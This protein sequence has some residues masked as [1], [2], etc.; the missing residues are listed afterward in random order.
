MWLSVKSMWQVKKISESIFG[1]DISRILIVLDLDKTL[2]GSVH[3]VTTPPTNGRTLT[4]PIVKGRLC[5]SR[6]PA[7]LS[8]LS[9]QGADVIVLTARNRNDIGITEET[10][11]TLLP[12]NVLFVNQP[13]ET[14][15]WYF[16]NGVCSCGST[17]KGDVLVELLSK[18]KKNYDCIVVVDD[19][20]DNLVSYIKRLSATNNRFVAIL[21]QYSPREIVT[22][23]LQTLQIRQNKH[24]RIHTC[25][26]TPIDINEPL[27]G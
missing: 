9:E 26:G 23:D 17:A 22:G 11:R 19:R 6:T 21:Y 16:A 5:D 2:I 15:N 4:A 8:K 12:K 25:G 27:T 20:E 3:I 18:F 7:V 13:H 10:V 1:V 14:P 24:I